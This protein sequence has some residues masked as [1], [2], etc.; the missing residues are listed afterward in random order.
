M[1]QVHPTSR[2]RIKTLTR[3]TI[4]IFVFRWRYS[5][6]QQPLV[7]VGTITDSEEVMIL[8]SGHSKARALKHAIEEGINQM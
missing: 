8:A 2:T 3:E 5:K 1:N 6:F 4:Q 7:G